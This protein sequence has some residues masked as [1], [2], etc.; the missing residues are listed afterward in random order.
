M[1]YK[2]GDLEKDE[3]IYNSE[4]A[5]MDDYPRC[6]YCSDHLPHKHEKVDDLAFC[7]EQC[8][9]EYATENDLIEKYFGTGATEEEVRTGLL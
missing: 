6:D 1:I 5:D 3:Y 4:W 7:S 9:I 8:I 2:H